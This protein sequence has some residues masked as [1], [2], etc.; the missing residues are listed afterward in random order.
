[1]CLGL[2]RNHRKVG[3]KAVGFNTLFAMEIRVLI[4]IT[5]KA[6]VL[7]PYNY[8]ALYYSQSSG[9]TFKPHCNPTIKLE[10]YYPSCHRSGKPG[11][12]NPCC[13]LSSW[14]QILRR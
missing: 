13:V 7:I 11:S 2:I 4:T 5:P 14:V 6:T 9:G 8:T 10:S 1:M 3:Q 12:E